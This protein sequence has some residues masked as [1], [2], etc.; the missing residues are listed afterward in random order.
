MK[1]L[2]IRKD[3]DAREDGRQEKGMIEDEMVARHHRLKVHEF[4]RALGDGEGQ[5]NLVCC[6]PVHVIVKCWT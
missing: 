3:P 1:S 5:R 6:S 2:L 4:E